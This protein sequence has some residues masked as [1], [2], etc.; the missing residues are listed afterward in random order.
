LS[1]LVRG[2]TLLTGTDRRRADLRCRDGRIAEIGTG[3][4]PAAGEEVVEAAGKLVLPGGVDPH[5]HLALPVAGTVSADDFAAGTAAALAGGTTTVIDFVHPRR[6]TRE[7][8]DR[9]DTG[10]PLLEALAERREEAA[11]AVA[12]HG[13]HMALTWWGDDSPRQMAACLEA[14]VP[15]FKLYLAY[16]DT[17]GLD[18]AQ[19]VRALAAAAELGATVLVHAEHGDAIELLRDRLAAEG[20]LGPEAH[21]ASRPPQLEGEATHRAA[22]LA[23]TFGTTL[24]V[25][26]VTCRESVEAVAAARRRGWDVHG[27]TCPQYLLLD[28]SEYRRPGFAGADYVIAPP[29]RPRNHQE[30]LWRA[31][32]D[33]TLEVVATDHCPFT[34]AQKELGRDDFRRIPGGAAGIE[35][36]L[37]LLWTHGVAAGRLDPHRF[38]DLVATCPA[39]LFGLHP[40]KGT[41]EPG[42]DADLVVWDPEATATIT[43]RTHRSKTDRSVYEGF[44]VTG[45]PAAVVVRG[46]VGVRDGR[47]AAELGEG[48]F[49]R[50]SRPS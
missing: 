12:D 42:A 39:R 25:V 22:A 33:G 17:V 7:R 23:G 26:H 6:G 2:G 10:Q 14:G 28:D 16:K 9:T 24:Y 1:L 27:E 30:A 3:L 40:R 44:E 8:P 29:L 19:A 49:Q 43:A 13:F 18:D 32:A 35:H 37:A 47:L 50:R 36:R 31:L 38:V 45:Q 5:V 41:L 46:R 20:R 4:E 34:H 15:S 21:P 48:H 11:G